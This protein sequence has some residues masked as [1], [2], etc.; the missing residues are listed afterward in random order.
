MLLIRDVSLFIG[1]TAIRFASVFD[2]YVIVTVG[3]DDKCVACRKLSAD[4]AVSYR[5]KNFVQV[6][7]DVTDGK[8]SYVILDMAGGND[9]DCH[10]SAAAIVLLR[11]ISV[12]SICDTWCGGSDR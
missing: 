1:T 12:S 2:A 6:V 10:Y 8:S 4:R 9:L 3:S 5:N 11:S 7:K